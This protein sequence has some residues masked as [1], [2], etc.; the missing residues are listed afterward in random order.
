LPTN[1]KGIWARRYRL[2]VQKYGVS[3]WT[4]STEFGDEDIVITDHTTVQ[5][6]RYQ[7]I[8]KIKEKGNA[9]MIYV[10]GNFAFRLY[11]DAFIKGSWEE[12]KQLLERKMK[13]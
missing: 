7:S 10:D 5:H 2:A 1:N 13:G 4:R 3:E 6:I 12:C 11:K 8:R 9:V